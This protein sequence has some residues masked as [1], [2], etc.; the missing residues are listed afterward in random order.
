M[1]GSIE[2]T[3]IGPRVSRFVH[4]LLAGRQA[5][6]GLLEVGKGRQ[7]FRAGKVQVDRVIGSKREIGV[8]KY[9]VVQG[10]AAIFLL[11]SRSAGRPAYV[12][13]S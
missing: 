2:S 4:Q 1:R 9:V 3:R 6:I 12:L 13:G 8:H 5:A 10:A 11:V 7:H